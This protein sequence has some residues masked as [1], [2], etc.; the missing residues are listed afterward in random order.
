MICIY[1]SKFQVDHWIMDL[2]P[3]TPMQHF[4]FV[5]SFAYWEGQAMIAGHELLHNKDFLTIVMGNLPYVQSMYSHFWEEHTRGHHK[6]I[7]TPVDPA[8]AEMGS[9]CYEHIWRNWTKTHV[10]SWN[11]GMESIEKKYGKDM[12]SF[13]ILSENNMVGYFILHAIIIGTIYQVFGSGGL[14]MHLIYALTGI[15]QIEVVNY[16]FHYG[17]ARAMGNDGIYESISLMDSW[18]STSSPTSWRISRHSD[19]HAHKFRP[20]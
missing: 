14:K 17:L 10:T 4:L 2:R 8:S 9:N 20:Y 12:S 11:R 19:H 3:Q 18:N 15:I 13:N 7:A 1:S 6:N 5:W 16:I